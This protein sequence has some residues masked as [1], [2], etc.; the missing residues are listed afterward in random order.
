MCWLLSYVNWVVCGHWAVSKCWATT[1]QLCVQNSF[2]FIYFLIR[3]RYVSMPYR[4]C[5]RVRSRFKHGCGTSATYR[6]SVAP[7]HPLVTAAVTP[8][9]PSFCFLRCEAVSGSPSSVD[10]TGPSR[11]DP[12]G[13]WLQDCP[14]LP[15]VVISKL[16]SSS[17]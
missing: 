10:P 1:Y 6:C 4:R 15:R 7:L 8:P 13:G 17:K 5:I 12:F 9:S 11:A 2:L 14:I 3:C 16:E